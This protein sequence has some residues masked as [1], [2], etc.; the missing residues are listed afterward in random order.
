MKYAVAFEKFSFTDRLLVVD[1]GVARHFFGRKC[2]IPGW[3]RGD[4]LDYASFLSRRRHGGTRTTLLPKRI[5]LKSSALCQI[6]KPKGT[7]ADPTVSRYTSVAMAHLAR[8]QR[9]H[10]ARE[11]GNLT[12]SL[13]KLNLKL[14]VQRAIR[15][16]RFIKRNF[17]KIDLLRD[18]K[19][20]IAKIKIKVLM[21]YILF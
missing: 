20:G 1:A 17:F 15:N 5:R 3:M 2:N 19:T 6:S 4:T 11:N 10:G 16:G 8:L 18:I 7:A 21:I 14:Y 12:C 9:S 13:R